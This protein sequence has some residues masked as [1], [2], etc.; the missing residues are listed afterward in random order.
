MAEVSG[1]DAA[2]L[3]FRLPDPDR[4]FAEV[5]LQQRIGLKATDFG[6]DERERA[7]T[8]TVPRPAAW[9]IEYQFELR[10]PDGRT[11]T[12]N[13]PGNPRRVEGAFGD[14]S[15]LECP[16]YAAP[17]WLDAPAVDG[18][19]LDLAIAAP[20]LG[21]DVAVRVWRPDRPTDLT[22]V[23]HDGPEF[24]RLAALSRFTAAMIA[25]GRVPAHRLVLVAP[26][27]RDDWYSA[28]PA[29]T[30]ALV[31]AV[32]PGVWREI[33][34]ARSTIG[35]GAS[36]GAL[37]MLHAHRRAPFAGLFLQ[38]GSFFLPRLDP[39]ERG[40]PRYGRIIRF[41][42]AA[43]RDPG[44]PVPTTLT[45]G[46]VEENLDNNRCMA[47]A[48]RSRGWPV[49]L[50]ETPDGHNFTAWRDALDPYLVDLL[51]RVWGDA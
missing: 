37:A 30:E 36:L 23:A 9:R 11:E 42:G 40:F 20:P 14:R 18:D 46:T 21:R 47:H 38:A 48:L 13:D 35:V 15:V 6:Y 39:Q 10:H 49:S 29:Y 4:A 16:G 24:D 45:C 25:A 8:L 50:A 33:G 44:A 19:W 5:R 32:L 2:E 31:D 22:L 17:A 41:V 28:N 51:G 7:W 3:W 12:I 1:C 27:D 26:G 34:G 43:M